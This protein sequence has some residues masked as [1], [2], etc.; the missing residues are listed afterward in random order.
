MAS[1]TTA[2]GAR[3]ASETLDDGIGVRRWDLHLTRCVIVDA[4]Q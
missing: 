3:S 1:T 4:L 2:A